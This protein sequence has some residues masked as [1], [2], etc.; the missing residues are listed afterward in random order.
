MANLTIQ[1]SF[2]YPEQS[3]YLYTYTLYLVL[4]DINGCCCINP[5][6][7]TKHSSGGTFVRLKINSVDKENYKG[8][9]IDSIQ[10]QVLK[11]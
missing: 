1:Y 7:L 10:A 11:I 4:Q 3:V 2:N 6:R 8:S 5:E 9:I